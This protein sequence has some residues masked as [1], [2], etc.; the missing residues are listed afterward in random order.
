M[1][2]PATSCG[3]RRGQAR[4]ALG[5]LFER[6]MSV[7][8]SP[9][10]AAAAL[11]FALLQPSPL[12]AQET[13]ASAQ[14]AT[15]SCTSKPGDRTQ[16]PADTSRGVVLVKSTGAAAC[17]L[18]KTWGYDQTSVW[19]SDGCSGEFATGTTADAQPTKV[20]APK[21]VPNVGFLLF[22]GE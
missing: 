6:V 4:P 20:G 13:A 7:R 11:A 16:C 3:K 12:H 1:R 8:I 5:V 15:V 9:G 10:P 19:V 18:G 14:P 22:D 2:L 21:H 17:L